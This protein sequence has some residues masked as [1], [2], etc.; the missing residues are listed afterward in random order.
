MFVPSDFCF[1]IDSDDLT[2]C[3]TVGR[4]QMRPEMEG[5]CFSSVITSSTEAC[6][7]VRCLPDVGG[8]GGV[9]SVRSLLSGGDGGVVFVGTLLDRA[10]SGSIGPTLVVR[11]TL[12]GSGSVGP[13]WCGVFV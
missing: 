4:V 7:S 11:S 1:I 10:A 5:R 2:F 8:E 9:G 6:V 3:I 12:F 13:G